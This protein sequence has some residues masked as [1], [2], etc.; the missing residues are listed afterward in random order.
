MVLSRP[1]WRAAAVSLSLLTAV[2]TVGLAP[3]A[4]AHER[5]HRDRDRVRVV[6]TGLDNPRQMSFSGGALYVAEAGEGGTADCAAGPEGRVC[7]GKSGSI[8]RVTA[9]GQRRVVTGLPSLAGETTGANAIGAGDVKV[10]GHRYAV[11]LGLGA[12][13]TSRVGKTPGYEKLATLSTGRLG[14]SRLR[15]VAD[16]GA[17]EIRSNPEPTDLDSN[18]VGLLSTGRSTYVA[19]AGGNTVYKVGRHGKVRTVAVLPSVPAAGFPDADAVPTSVAQG[20]DG[21]L[22]VSQLTGFPFPVGGSSIWRVVPGHAPTRYAT[23]LTNVTDLAFDRHGHLYAVQI[24]ANGLL[25]GEAARG[26]VVRVRPGHSTHT[27]IL[28]GLIAPYGIALHDGAA[29]VTIHA[30]EKNA[31]QVLRIP[32]HH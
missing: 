9:R 25:A 11:L 27:T 22:Y 12:D 29:Y 19:D 20:P 8:T 30:T 3:A 16:I 21:A 7:F 5:D 18:P 17:K 2:G 24:A 32:L 10:Y 13:P 14:S 4:T 31:G 6:A 28:G 1:G 23:G 26:S 15:V